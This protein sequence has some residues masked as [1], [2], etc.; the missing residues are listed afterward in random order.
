MAWNSHCSKLMEWIQRY[1]PGEQSEGVN[2][3]QL[4][5]TAIN[6]CKTT[7]EKQNNGFLVIMDY[8]DQEECEEEDILQQEEL[9]NLNE[10]EEN[11][12]V[13]DEEYEDNE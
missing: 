2:F 8:E 7:W 6:D 1:F 12:Q 10:N 9:V 3:S 4:W 13:I 11:I 5:N